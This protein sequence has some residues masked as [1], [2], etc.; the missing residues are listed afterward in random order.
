M[1]PLNL[2]GTSNETVK[3]SFSIETVSDIPSKYVTIIPTRYFMNI[4]NKFNMKK[5]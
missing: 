4:Y 2:I 5:L 3:D 1:N